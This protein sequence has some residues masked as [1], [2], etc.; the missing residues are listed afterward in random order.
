M[1]K[2]RYLRDTDRREVDFVVL[3]DGRPLWAVECKTGDRAIAAP[4]R[5]FAARTPIPHFYQ[6]HRGA[7]HYAS[8]NITVVPFARFCTDLELP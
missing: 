1:R 4:V 6:V 7:R 3:R 2:T 5:Y 8:G